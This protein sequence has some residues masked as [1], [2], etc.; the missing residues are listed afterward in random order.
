[1]K[2]ALHNYQPDTMLRQKDGVNLAYNEIASLLA[3]D[4]GRDL[5]VRF[6]DFLQLCADKSYALEMLSD[7]DCVISNVGPHAHYYFYLREK[8][9]LSFRIVRDVRE[10]YRSNYLL[11]EHLCRAYLRETDLVL[12]AS[13]YAQ[14]VFFHAYPH[15]RDLPTAICYPLMRSFPTRQAGKRKS[16]SDSKQVTLGYV[17]RLS[18]DKNFPQLVDL[19]IKL[20]AVDP[21]RYRLLALGDIHSPSCDPLKL[22]EHV[23]SETGRDDLFQYYPPVG[24]DRVWE[25]YERLDV[26]VFLSTSNIETFGRVLI[27]A[28]YSGVPIIASDHAAAPELLPKDSTV[29]VSY[30]TG[31]P[32]S[33]HYDFPLGEVNV[34]AILSKL[35][36][37]EVEQGKAHLDYSKHPD[38]FLSLL[39]QADCCPDTVSPAVRDAQ[40]EHCG[41]FIESV[42]LIGMPEPMDIPAANGLM[43]DMLAWFCALQDKQAPG[44]QTKLEELLRIS[45]ERERTLRYIR[46]SL[47]SR[48]DFTNVGGVDFELCHIAGFFPTFE[49]MGPRKEQQAI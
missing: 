35:E 17:G 11:Q 20:H 39:R 45:T 5:D 31:R 23:Q 37:G 44:Y 1:M 49:I 41:R 24:H 26:F 13:I 28:S 9:G 12:F 42:R 33:A 15:L 21:G 10:A 40:R 27:E 4:P 14:E 19:I 46:K 32:F 36:F 7:V 18:E 47:E 38:F 43:S 16:I 3:K 22:M 6:H 48:G 25:F 34:P 29:P 8:L 2:I 30:Y